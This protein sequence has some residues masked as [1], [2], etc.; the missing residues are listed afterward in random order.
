MELSYI[1]GIEE[2]MRAAYDAIYFEL[3]HLIEEGV[4][5]YRSY[6]PSEST[7]VKRYGCAHNTVRKALAALACDGYAQP[8]HGRGVRVI[9]QA[10]SNKMRT[11]SRFSASEIEPFCESG[12]RYGFKATTKVLSLEELVADEQLAESTYFEVGEKLVHM[13]R[14]RYYDGTPLARE[15]NYFRADIVEGMTKEDAESSVYRYIEYVRNERLVTSKRRVT[16]ERADDRDAELLEIGDASWI[17]VLRVLTFDGNGLLCEFSTL[18][19]HPS[20]FSLDQTV[21]RT[22]ISG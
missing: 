18:R 17:A 14:V 12:E 16:V 22:R 3:K 20:V 13:E 11:I 21:I 15:S 2:S 7:L 8:I 1:E 5:P 4:Y 6:L 10:F 19:H 9:Y